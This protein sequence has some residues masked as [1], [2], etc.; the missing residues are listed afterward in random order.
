LE[1]NEA[2][3]ECAILVDKWGGDFPC[4]LMALGAE[5]EALGIPE[6]SLPA[7]SV[8]LA[9]AIHFGC[10]AFVGCRAMHLASAVQQSLIDL[11]CIITSVASDE[12]AL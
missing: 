3:E 6:R 5:T 1:K 8:E 12:T 11:I 7:R 4:R 10:R 2:A 9:S